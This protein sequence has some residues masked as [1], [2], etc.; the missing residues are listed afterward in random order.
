M[1]KLINKLLGKKISRSLSFLKNREFIPFTYKSLFKPEYVYSDFFILNTKFFRNVFIAENTFSLL[2]TKKLPVKH[3]L[4]FYGPNGD[5]LDTK[6]YISDDFITNIQLPKFNKKETYLSFTHQ[7]I[8]DL[9]SGIQLKKKSCGNL[10]HI[11]QVQ[12]A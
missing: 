8:I 12:K 1:K 4:N 7:T 5:L 2:N 9:E 6:T 10:Q 3:I 11:T